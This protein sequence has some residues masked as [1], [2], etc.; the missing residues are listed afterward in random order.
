MP[1]TMCSHHSGILFHTEE[2]GGPQHDMELL[3]KQRGI[4][5]AWVSSRYLPTFILQK[6][7]KAASKSIGELIPLAFGAFPGVKWPTYGNIG[8]FR[9]S[10][11][12]SV[13]ELTNGILRAPEILFGLIRK[14][15]RLL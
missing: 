7:G 4:T 11:W 10:L 3:Y 8:S 6:S 2:T 1:S 14:I 15:E 13:P 9:T 12:Y 5:E